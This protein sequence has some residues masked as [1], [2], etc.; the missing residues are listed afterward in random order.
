MLYSKP[1][2]LINQQIDLLKKRGLIIDDHSLADHWLKF[3]GYYRLSGYWWSMQDDKVA[4]IF[5]TN[6]TFENVIALYSFDKELRIVIFSEIEKIEIAF[7]TLL[8]Y[9][10]S[11]EI[12]PWWFEDENNF[13][14]SVKHRETLISIDRELQQ[15]KETFIKQH[16]IK[17]H[18]ET[19]RPPSWKTLEIASFGNC[20]RLYGNLKNSISSKNII[21]KVLGTVN[22][23]YLKS[24]LMTIV[25]IRNIC[26][27]HGRLWNRNLPGRP[28][29]LSKPPFA[30]ISDVPEVN[31]HYK[32]YVH[33]CCIKYLLNV[34]SPDNSFT[35]KIQGLFLKYKNVD[36][37]A[38][39]MK[40]DWQNEVLW[41]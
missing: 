4:H 22:H 1:P 29:L 35:N 19:R 15:T 2:I 37:N 33:L 6:S 8:M 25:Q 14:D 18:T 23:T 3:V 12:S 5:K 40:P 30:W 31:E 38:L 10:L 17:Y 9:N 28:K 39:G 20:S 41:K 13:K 36:Q 7:R 16:Y 26:A 11:N 21:S 34:I 24:W 32:L 27:H